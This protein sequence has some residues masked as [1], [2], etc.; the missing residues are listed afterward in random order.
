MPGESYRDGVWTVEI[1]GGPAFLANATAAV[2]LAA[3]NAE[4]SGRPNAAA[5]LDRLVEA[6][7]VA[8]PDEPPGR[9]AVDVE[10]R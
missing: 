8:H 9:T 6:F 10:I 4:A 5:V 7:I 1:P 2:K 3:I